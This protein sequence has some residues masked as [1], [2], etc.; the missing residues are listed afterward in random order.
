V[1]MP[2]R[3]ESLLQKIRRAIPRPH[4]MEGVCLRLARAADTVRR[5]LRRQRHR[6][7]RA[8]LGADASGLRPRTHP[9]GLDG[10]APQHVARDHP[11]AIGGLILL[12]LAPWV[13]RALAASD[14]GGTLGTKPKPNAGR[15]RR[16]IP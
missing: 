3:G 14:R 16:V 15:R 5:Q 12:P 9:C 7:G 1:R 8:T 13:I 4:D 10:R 6:L 2:V 11:V